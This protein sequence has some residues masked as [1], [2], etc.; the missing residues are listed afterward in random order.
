V[1][2]FTRSWA[3]TKPHEAKICGPGPTISPADDL[4]DRHGFPPVDIQ[5]PL[6]VSALPRP[7]HGRW[8][9][10]VG[11][12]P[13]LRLRR[14]LR[15]SRGSLGD[16]QW[17]HSEPT[18]RL[19][20]RGQSRHWRLRAAPRSLFTTLGVNR[21]SNRHA[22]NTNSNEGQS[23]FEM[24]FYRKHPPDRQQKPAEN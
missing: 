23:Q 7:T 15:P 18:R 22:P 20:L 16:R 5:P 21:E 17:F 19:Q 8:A 3:S 24:C 9:A 6:R 2:A 12:S 10:C 4:H 14:L 11:R 13:D 1:H